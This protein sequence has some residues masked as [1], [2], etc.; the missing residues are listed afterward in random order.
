[1]VSRIVLSIDQISSSSF[2]HHHLRLGSSFCRWSCWGFHWRDRPPTPFSQDLR[3]PSPLPV[4]LSWFTPF[5][6]MHCSKS[7]LEHELVRF[8]CFLLLLLHLVV[9]TC[10][11][12]ATSMSTLQSVWSSWCFQQF[13]TF[14]VVLSPMFSTSI[15]HRVWF[16]C[17][18]ISS[19][20][21]IPPIMFP[22][23]GTPMDRLLLHTITVNCCFRCRLLLSVC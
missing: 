7:T 10:N 23:C 5:P 8:F 3:W 19:F 17:V 22:W 14:V 4:Y 1:M 16:R 6:I 13:T 9:G 21:V 2:Y 18:L 20:S 12:G 11:Q 15:H